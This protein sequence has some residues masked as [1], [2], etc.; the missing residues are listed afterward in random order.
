VHGSLLE[1][2]TIQVNPFLTLMQTPT[3]VGM[4]GD[5]DFLVDGHYWIAA[6]AASFVGLSKGG[7]PSI[8]MLAVPLLSLFMSPVQAAALLLPIYVISDGFGVY[9]YRHDFSRINLRILIP[10][11]IFGVWLGWLTAHMVSERVITFLIGALG[12]A[13]CLNVWLRKQHFGPPAPA[14]IGKGVFWGSLAGFTSFISHAGGPPFQMFMLPQRLSKAEFAGTAT[15]LF[16]VIN[17]AKIAPY[18][19]LRPYSYSTLHSA[20]LLTPFA[21][22]GAVAGAWLTRRIADAWFYRLVQTSL[23]C[24]S[25]KLVIDAVVA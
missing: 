16:A 25:I 18:Q 6:V 4:S 19:D 14:H 17:L 20:A 8:S 5:L 22:V 21:L 11:G 12:V 9:L 3:P 2:C 13:F 24:V 23:F 1:S 10:A 15:I 7:L